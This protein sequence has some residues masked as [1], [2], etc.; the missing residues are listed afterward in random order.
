MKKSLIAVA[1]LA[2][3]LIAAPASAQMSSALSSVYVGA[4]AGQ[5]EFKQACDGAG[6]G[7]ESSDT[8]WRLLGGYQFNRNFAAEIGY[9][10][11]G[12]IGDSTGRV[13]ASAWELNGL[14]A[15]P[16]TQQLSGYFKLGAYYG[17]FEG[18]G[19]DETN[20]GLT[21]GVGGQYDIMRNLGLRLEWQR[22]NNMG[23]NGAS[24]DVDVFSIGGIFRFN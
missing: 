1:G 14:L 24:T 15:L 16:V 19:T 7:C 2:A 6:P 5:A 20:T 23:D 10:N 21:F 18:G 8:A 3:A 4:T 12:S 11:L 17:Q 9:H 22:Y 13:D